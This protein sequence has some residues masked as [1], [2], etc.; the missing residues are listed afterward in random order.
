MTLR[1]SAPGLFNNNRE[2]FSSLFLLLFFMLCGMLLSFSIIS[3][4]REL[5][6]VATL[7]QILTAALSTLF[8]MAFPAILYGFVWCRRKRTT[9]VSYFLGLCRVNSRKE[10]TPSSLFFLLLLLTFVL[11]FLVQG[12]SYLM[13]KVLPYMPCSLQ[14]VA[15]KAKLR[16]EMR[17]DLLFA[18]HGLGYSFLRIVAFA[19]IPAFS[20][21]LFMRGALQPILIKVFRNPH[22]GIVLTAILFAG[23]H[24]SVFNFLGIFIYALY[25]GYLA[26]Y[27]RSIYP[28]V[29]LHFLNNFATLAIF[30]FTQLV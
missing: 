15:E 8:T 23:L 7:S 12:S 26:Y 22:W 14:E 13:E 2:A 25:F 4:L 17:M 27:L 18:E 6:L 19:V 28:G 21:E 29:I 30:Y 5:Q 11:F 1:F 3:L 10:I 20:E 9:T 16:D 24:L